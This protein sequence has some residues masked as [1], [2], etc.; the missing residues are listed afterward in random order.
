LFAGC[1]SKKNTAISRSYHNLTS[2]YNVYFNGMEAYKAGQKKIAET[3]K[4]NYSLVLPP[5]VWSDKE[6]ARSAYGDMNR[7][8]EKGSKCIRK[9]SITV[10]PKKKEGKKEKKNQDFYNK[11]EYVKWI[12]D[13]YLLVGKSQ[14][15]KHDYYAAIE[16]FTYVVRQFNDEKSKY[17]AYLWIARCY[18]EMEKY[19]KADEFIGN[20]TADKSK[21]PEELEGPLAITQADILLKQKKYTEAIPFI[22]TACEKTS[23]KKTRTRYLYILAQ[24]YQL[25]DE[26]KKAFETYGKVIDLNPDYEMI[27]NARINRA[28]IFNSGSGSSLPLQKELAKML[29]DDKNI[30]FRDQIYYALGNIAFNESRDGDAMNFYKL[31]VSSSTNNPNQKGISFLAIADMYFSIPD[32]KNSQLYYDSTVTSLTKEYPNYLN[33]KRKSE[34]L[35]E[36]VKNME[37]IYDQDSLIK[38]AAMSETDRNRLIDKMISQVMEEEQKA[39]EQEAIQKNELAYMEQ[40]GR[41][42]NTQSNTGKWY[43]Y[44]PTTL[45]M[46]QSEF[47]KKWGDRRLEDNWRR[48]NKSEMNW[49]GTEAKAESSSSESKTKELSNKSREYYMANL[50][51]TDSAKAASMELIE[52]AYFNLGTVYKEKFEDF[53]LSIKTYLELVAKFPDSKFKLGAL[54]N[55]YKLYLLQKD[56]TNAE[57]Y[58]QTII[59]DYPNS[60]YAR[61][62]SDPEYFKQLEKVESQLNFMYM[63]TYNFFLDDSCEQ[64]AYNYHYLDT[65]FPGSPLLSKF[66]LLNTLCGG[67]S[68]DTLKFKADLNNFIKMF[69]NSDE[70][71]YALDVLAALDRKPHEVELKPKVIAFGEETPGEVPIDS[72][73]ISMYSYNDKQEHYYLIVV[74]TQKADANLIKFN[75]S[76]FNLDNF[77]FLEFDISSIMLSANY[78]VI[79]VKKFKNMNMARNYMEWITPASEIFEGISSDSY[80]QYLISAPNFTKFYDDK[81]VARYQKFY[82]LNYK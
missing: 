6:A 82:N 11:N 66:A 24:L 76:N 50:P 45:S 31:S 75:I 43:F 67:H 64:V 72:I 3:H 52:E 60:D 19:N 54:Y 30:E 49:E 32:Y 8:I 46:G 68:G 81:N 79:V 26:N 34:N 44:N 38:V 9:H 58:K 25:N 27:F 57:N 10:K 13:G 37:I 23:A 62:L 14:L 33:I 29:K 61:I 16:T 51:L 36:L 7:A 78:S 21:L 77:S 56:Y 71:A 41:Q 1:S 42:Q 40:Q 80:R 55:L 65:T 35:N 48:S 74:S 4:D 59:K 70:K 53:D 47:K 69:P 39:K 28:S 15:M 12:D 2:Y 20:L 5:F 17:D 63:A 18:A 73:D 22:E